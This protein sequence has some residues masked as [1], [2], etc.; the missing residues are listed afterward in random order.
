[1]SGFLLDTNNLTV[2]SR[3]EDGYPNTGVRVINPFT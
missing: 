2:V 1:M 3:A